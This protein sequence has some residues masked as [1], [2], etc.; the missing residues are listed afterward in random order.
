M[1]GP[2]DA[3]QI[4]YGGEPVFSDAGVPGSP[5]A[6]AVNWAYGA[7]IINGYGDGT[8]RPDASITREEIAV[9]LMRHYKWRMENLELET[10]DISGFA[11]AGSVSGWAEDAMR[12]AVGAG[13]IRGSDGMM[14]PQGTAT[15]AQTAQMILNYNF[16]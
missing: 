14:I 5:L 12:W 9:M 4:K 11:D 8:F 6:V 10:G 16:V 15:R 3:E 13:I 1:S 2:G 7:G